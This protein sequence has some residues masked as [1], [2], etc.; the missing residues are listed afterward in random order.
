MKGRRGYFFVIDAIIA[1]TILLFGLFIIFGSG[2]RTTETQQPFIAAEDFSS[3]VLDKSLATST[4]SYYVTIL[5]PAGLVPYPDATP[6]EEIAYLME[7]DPLTCFS[8]ASYA[9]NFSRSLIDEALDSHYGVAIVYN[10]T[11]VYSRTVPKNDLF[12]SRPS[13]VYTRMNMTTVIGPV[14]GEVQVWY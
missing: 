14:T 3:L 13:I 1:A 4:N 9:A 11:T 2:I 10:G 12:L 7:R 6:M 5:L 8:C